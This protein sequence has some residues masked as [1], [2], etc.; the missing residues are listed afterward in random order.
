MLLKNFINFNAL[1]KLDNQIYRK[2]SMDMITPH[3]R[4]LASNNFEVFNGGSKFRNGDTLFARITP[5]LE[6]GKTAY[7]NSLNDNE[8]AFGSTEFIVARAVENVSLPLFVY[9]LLCSK[10]VRNIAIASMIGS[11][12][13]ER[14]QQIALDNIEIPQYSL[15]TQQHIVVDMWLTGFD[16]PDLDTMY[17]IKKLKS[18]NLMQ[19]IA[20]VNRVYPG[21]SSGLI[22]DY[23]GLNKALDAALSEYTDRDRKDNCQDIKKE[24]YNILREKLSILNEWFIKIDK[25]K[26]N[27]NESSERFKAIQD[28]V[29][30]ILS[31]KNRE[32]VFL[33]DL[34][35]NIK[36]AFAACG[37]MATE[38]EKSDTIYYLAIRSYILKLRMGADS[39]SIQE[40]NEQVKEL[41]ADAIQG[42]EVKLLGKN[43]ESIN[44]IELLTK[45]KMDALRKSNPP[46]VFIEIVKKLLER[47]ITESRKNN[48]F[49]YQEYSKR[50][51]KI[52]EKYND[53]DAEFTADVTIAGL[54]DF[55]SEL[56]SDEKKANNLG[57]TGRERAF[58]DALVRDKSAKE[59]MSDETLK[60]IALELKDIVEEY[61]KTDWS[62]KLATQANMR[63]KI[64]ECLKKYGYPPEYR[65][66]A[67]GDVLEQ[68]R[69]MMI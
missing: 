68:A 38:E 10:T 28:G 9:Y 59:L 67:I 1:E 22:A 50:L 49:K 61:A 69:F 2:F 62:L 54:V 18:Y 16:V 35:I 21:K 39:V 66:A 3:S 57:I 34:S 30:F 11:S 43:D 37:G 41:L 26:F 14:V 27:S 45:E 5:C 53:R 60:L 52:L 48:Y 7:V 13:R 36:Q 47:A 19:A 24:I 33:K 31:D 64:K 40:M 44:V 12:G 56:V 55:A 8:I 51:R 23:I 6:N 17:F 20:R 25:E 15:P 32:D 63:I 42:D 58:Y 29:E 46:H 65:D 4:Y